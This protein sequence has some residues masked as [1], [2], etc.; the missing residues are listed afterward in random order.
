MNPL[1]TLTS[2]CNCENFLSES[3]ASM[4]NTQYCKCCG[5][6]FGLP[7]GIPST[8]MPAYVFRGPTQYYTYYHSDPCC[9][10]KC[11]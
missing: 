1:N 3:L 8:N 11:S 9:C 10:V 7:F 6:V 5:A 4:Y 2:N